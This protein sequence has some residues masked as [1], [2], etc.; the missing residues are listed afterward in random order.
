MDKKLDT[1]NSVSQKP[2]EKEI[3][4]WRSFG[5]LHNDPEFLKAKNDEFAEGVTDEFD[6]NKM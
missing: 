6:I 5:E 4:Y 3:H 1:T 2:E